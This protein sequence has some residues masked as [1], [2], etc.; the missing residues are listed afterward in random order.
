[1]SL[2]DAVGGWWMARPCTGWRMPPA[3]NEKPPISSSSPL[4]THPPSSSFPPSNLFPLSVPLSL[5]SLFLPL[6]LFLHFVSHPTHTLS[7]VLSSPLL[8][9]SASMFPFFIRLNLISRLCTPLFFLL[10]F[11]VLFL[12][13]FGGKLENFL[14]TNP[15]NEPPPPPVLIEETLGG[16][17]RNNYMS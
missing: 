14:R 5:F 2:P 8:V 13:I 3:S 15:I 12:S 6:Y 10:L 9:V 17:I 16:S 4:W 1:M 11:S 7:F